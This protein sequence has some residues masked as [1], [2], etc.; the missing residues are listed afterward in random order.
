M[1]GIA[2]AINY[3]SEHFS[4]K[5]SLQQ[6]IKWLWICTDWFGNTYGTF[7]LRCPVKNR[8]GSLTLLLLF[9]EGMSCLASSELHHSITRREHGSIWW[10]Q[11][12]H[13]RWN[14][15]EGLLVIVNQ[16]GYSGHPTMHCCVCRHLCIR[17]RE[18]ERIQDSV[19][20]FFSVTTSSIIRL[21]IWRCLKVCEKWNKS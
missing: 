17:Q 18:R 6:K 14:S 7:L 4:K 19:Y 10:P 16:T 20:F 21:S 13:A 8:V 2:T 1:A 15:A 12:R 11:V 9:L 5:D 3:D